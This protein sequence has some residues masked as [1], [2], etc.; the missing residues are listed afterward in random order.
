MTSSVPSINQIRVLGIV[1]PIFSILFTVFR[2]CVRV[3]RRQLWWDDALAFFSLLCLIVL[4][5]AVAL[6][7]KDPSEVPHRS[8]IAAYYMSAQFFYAVAW[9]ARLSILFTVIRISFSTLRRVLIIVAGIFIVTW[10]I[11][12]AQVLWIC[13]GDPS[14]KSQPVPQCPLGKDV[15]IAQVITDVITDFILILAPVRLIWTTLL[16]K[17][18]KTRLAAVFGSTII[19]TAISMYHAWAVIVMG[20]LTES[21]AAILQAS[22]SLMVANLSVIIAFIFRITPTTKQSENTEPLHLSFARPK[23]NASSTYGLV[24]IHESGA[25]GASIEP[26]QA[27]LEDSRTNLVKVGKATV[28]ELGSVQHHAHDAYEQ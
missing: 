19:T 1:L 18:L 4:M 16:D 17:I 12:I 23:K 10:M 27:V 7:V 20:G 13:E 5:V 2:L 6:F 26:V 25:D 14:W 22:I 21:R 3:I 15:A 8:K 9:S 24:S 28:W 11:L